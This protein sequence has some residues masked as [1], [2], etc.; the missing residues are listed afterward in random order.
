MIVTKRL[1]ALKLSALLLALLLTLG[2]LAVT[3]CNENDN[4]GNQA[5]APTTTEKS[6][7]VNANWTIKVNDK[8]TVDSQGLPI[9]YT[10]QFTATKAGGTDPTGSYKGTAHLTVKSDL[11]KFKGLPQSV[12]KVMGSID[13]QGDDKNLTFKVITFADAR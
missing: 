1:P 6:K 10:L 11:S 4:G 7:E 13:G 2:A 8:H 9:D 12:I 5:K 3:G